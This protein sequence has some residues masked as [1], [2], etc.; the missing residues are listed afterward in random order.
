MNTVA[1]QFSRMLEKAECGSTTFNNKHS[2][3]VKEIQGL[4]QFDELL[5]QIYLGTKEILPLRIRQAKCYGPKA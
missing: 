5:M 2:F 1:Y 3:I 4:L